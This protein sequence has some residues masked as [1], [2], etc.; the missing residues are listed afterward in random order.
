MEIIQSLSPDTK[1][2]TAPVSLAIGNFDGVHLGHMAVLNYIKEI[3]AKDG[4]KTGVVTFENH[5]AQV[6][7]PQAAPLNICTLG[8]KIRL[9]EESGIDFLLLLKFT[10]ELSQLTAKEFL[11]LLKAYIPF[12]SLNMGHDGTIGKDRQGNEHLMMQLAKEHNF[13]LNYL[14]PLE[15]QGEV[16]SSSKIRQIIREGDLRKTETFLGR[17][18]SIYSTVVSGYQKGREI[19]FPTANLD[20]SGL[21]TPPHGVYTV[22]ALHEGKIYPGIAN[23]GISPTLKDNPN[24]V[25]DVHLFDVDLDLYNKQIEV[26]FHSYIRP[27]QKFNSIDQL[28]LQISKD[29]SI[30]KSEHQKAL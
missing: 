7:R 9:L 10:K 11:T 23:L 27:E 4:T 16:V 6:L 22:T 18:Y 28:K 14:Y 21:C 20:V 30:A 17:K 29:I 26:I 13:S 15:I 1:S 25:L 24:P 2:S 3:A 8:H 5:P 19:G 12:Y